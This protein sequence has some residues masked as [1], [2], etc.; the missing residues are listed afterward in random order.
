MMLDININN[1]ILILSTPEDID[2]NL[3]IEWLNYKKIPVFRLNDE[4][5][6]MGRT[7]IKYTPSNEVLIENSSKSINVNDVKIVWYRKFGFLTDYYDVF[8]GNNDLMQYMLSEFRSLKLFLFETLSKKKWLCDRQNPISKMEM[9]NKAKSVKI[10]IPDTIICTRKNE[11]EFFFLKNNMSIITKSIG[12]ARFIKYKTHGFMFH[13]HKIENINDFDAVF[14]PSLFQ[15]YIE[16]TIEIR[17]FYLNEECYSMAI[18]SQN[19]ENTKLDFRNYD[20]EIP[21]RFVPYKLPEKLEKKITVFMKSINL[22][23]GSLDLIKSSKDDD[24]YFLEVNPCGQFGMT[25]NPC[26]YNLHEKVANFLIK[27]QYEN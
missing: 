10:K 8:G 9:L 27:A 1:M 2:T 6:M 19:N 25:S 11:L 12:D 20:S 3:V 22:N 7:N 15:E 16:K 5:L 13:T 17:T 18:F 24:Y 26:N 14:S 4:D 21:N 23:T